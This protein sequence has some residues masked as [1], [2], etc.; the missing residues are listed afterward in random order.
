MFHLL[1]LRDLCLNFAKRQMTTQ[2]PA[3]TVSGISYQDHHLGRP[4]IGINGNHL[5]EQPAPSVRITGKYVHHG[6]HRD[7]K[8][9]QEGA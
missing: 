7:Q 1:V 4:V 8:W 6:S 2:S 3:V 5:D 9:R